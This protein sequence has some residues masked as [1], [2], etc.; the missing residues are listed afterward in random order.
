MRNKYSIYNKNLVV[1]CYCLCVLCGILCAF[2]VKETAE[3]RK[4][5]MHAEGAERLFIFENIF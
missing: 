4:E 1:V 2:A 3:K 5:G